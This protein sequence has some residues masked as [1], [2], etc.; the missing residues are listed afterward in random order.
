M[1]AQMDRWPADWRRERGGHVH[2]V[3]AGTGRVDTRSRSPLRFCRSLCDMFDAEGA[4]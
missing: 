4:S 2:C 1:D 3:G